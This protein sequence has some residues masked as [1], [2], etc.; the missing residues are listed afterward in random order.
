MWI[1]ISFASQ[2]DA[3]YNFKKYK[4]KHLQQILIGEFQFSEHKTL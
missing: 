4:K 1:K 2:K 3:A